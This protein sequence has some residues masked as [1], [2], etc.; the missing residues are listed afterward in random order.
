VETAHSVV[1]RELS[2]KLLHEMPPR[3]EGLKAIEMKRPIR[4][5]VNEL[6]DQLCGQLTNFAM[7]SGGGGI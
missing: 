4:A 1:R 7:G 2:K 5:V 6:S 3:L